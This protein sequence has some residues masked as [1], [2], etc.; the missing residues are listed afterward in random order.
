MSSFTPLHA[1]IFAI[2]I[3]A[4]INRPIKFSTLT[5]NQNY[6]KNITCDLKIKRCVSLQ[7]RVCRLRVQKEESMRANQDFFLQ[8]LPQRFIKYKN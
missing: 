7:E 6:E 2:K 8:R 1:E 4:A 5:I 3:K